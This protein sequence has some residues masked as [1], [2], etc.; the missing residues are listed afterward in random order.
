MPCAPSEARK[1]LSKYSEN[2]GSLDD[3]LCT[4]LCSLCKHGSRDDIDDLL[5]SL[6]PDLAS[7]VNEKAEGHH[8]HTGGDSELARHHRSSLRWKEAW[9]KKR[10]SMRVCPNSARSWRSTS[11]QR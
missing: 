10:W 5:Y 7:T 8:R 11:F 9:K 1:L 3:E 4:F 2:G 6:C